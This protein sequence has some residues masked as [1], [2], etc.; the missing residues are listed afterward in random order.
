MSPVLALR[1]AIDDLKAL[2][3]EEMKVV[4]DADGMLVRISAPR[5]RSC[6][7]GELSAGGGARL[8]R[9]A[10]SLASACAPAW[11]CPLGVSTEAVG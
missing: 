2:A 1:F 6:H 11:G 10:A 9:R 7:R 3:E 8:R 4:L 5:R